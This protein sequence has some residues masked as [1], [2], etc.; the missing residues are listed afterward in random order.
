MKKN[1][2]SIF[3]IAVSASFIALMVTGC[4]KKIESWAYDYEPTEEVAAFYK[5]GK[6]VFKGEKYTYVKDDSYI[7]FTGKDETLKLRYTEDDGQMVLYEK[8]TYVRSAQTPGAELVGAWYSDTVNGWSYEFNDRGEFSEDGIFYGYYSIDEDNQRIMLMYT[9][10]VPNIYI[11]YE[12]DG[13]NLTISY[14]WTLVPT[15]QS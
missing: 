7:T 13:D 9:Y 11:Y 5:G 6:A 4:G 1:I 10:P 8:A 15:T 14:P 2:I 3:L 12:M